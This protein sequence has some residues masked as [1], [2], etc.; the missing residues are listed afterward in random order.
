MKKFLSVF[1]ILLAFLSYSKAA[2]LGYVDIEKVMNN[3]EKGKK[4][5]QDLESKFK[6]Y[7]TKAKELQ[8]KI[9]S[10][11]KQLQSSTLNEKAKEEKRKE[12][13]DLARQL[14]NLE[15]QANEELAKIKADAEK[16]MIAEIKNITAKIAKNKNIDIVFYGGLIS[17]VLYADKKIDITDE[18]LKEFNKQK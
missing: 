18:V 16:K 15:A 13:R 11:Q 6:Y 3:S 12:L 8:D 9:E 14:Q 4:Y 17:G 10:L 5:K 2:T 1:L 7:Q